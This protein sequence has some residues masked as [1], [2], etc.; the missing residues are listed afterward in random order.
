LLESEHAE[1]EKEYAALVTIRGDLL[2][3]TTI[4]D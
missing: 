3:V 1:R 2:G 4:G